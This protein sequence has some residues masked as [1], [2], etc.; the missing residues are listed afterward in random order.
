MKFTEKLVGMVN[1]S[2][3][4]AKNLAEGGLNELRRQRIN[5]MKRPL[6]NLVSSYLN[7]IEEV[8]EAGKLSEAKEAAQKFMEDWGRMEK[9][10]EKDLLGYSEDNELV[11]M[12]ELFC[13]AIQDQKDAERQEE[14]DR[15]I[16]A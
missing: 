13:Q 12:I 11:A 15:Q 2:Q 10:P 9:I 16:N 4:K 6:Q 5:D 7:N 1:R 3:D 14:Q 8:K